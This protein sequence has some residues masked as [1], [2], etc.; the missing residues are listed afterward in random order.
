[1]KKVIFALIALI[2]LTV[3]PSFA[4]EADYIPL[5]FTF[6]IVT[7]NAGTGA[8]SVV[9]FK[10]PENL[11]IKNIYVTETSGVTASSTD[12][13]TF[14][15]K[16]GASAIQAYSTT[17]ALVAMTPKAFTKVTTANAHRVAKDA[18]LTMVVTK[19]GAGVALTTPVVQL[20]YTIGW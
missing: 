2:A 9:T 11:T 7:T 16:N 3:A 4:L 13:A 14:T 15:L 5:T 17:T 20:N 8:T 10:A 18:V 6:P 19:V 1:M 12:Y